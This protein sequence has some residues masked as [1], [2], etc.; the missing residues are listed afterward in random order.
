MVWVSDL[1]RR[2]GPSA[3]ESGKGHPQSH[4]GV[5]RGFWGTG[6]QTSNYRRE[7]MLSGIRGTCWDLQVTSRSYPWHRGN[8]SGHGGGGIRLQLLIILQTP[9]RTWIQ[10]RQAAVGGWVPSFRGRALLD[11]SSSSL[12]SS[13]LLC[14]HSQL[15]VQVPAVPNTPNPFLPQDLCPCSSLCLD[16][17]PAGDQ[18]AHSSSY[19][20]S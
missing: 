5:E 13:S 8:P 20:S 11:A 17:S 2:W 14:P 7:I 16:H 3:S 9:P 15:A 10:T 1:S 18:R 4:K 19:C 12:M 6:L